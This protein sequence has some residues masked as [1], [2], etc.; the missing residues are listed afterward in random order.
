MKKVTREEAL[1]Y[2]RW[3]EDAGTTQESL[4]ERLGRERSTITNMLRLLKLPRAIQQDLIDERLSMGHAR[5][6]AGLRDPSEQKRL[7]D[8]ILSK[9]DGSLKV[10]AR[11]ETGAHNE[12]RCPP[13]TEGEPCWSY[14]AV[15]EFV[16]GDDP[17]YSTI[18]LN[19]SGTKIEA[20]ELMAFEE[21]T[22]LVFSNGGYRL[23]DEDG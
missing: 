20:G 18:L 7:R 14:A 9:V 1:A 16:P 23:I 15:Y 10:V 4:A 6:L 5:V 11:I 2:Q 21:T 22:R 12:Q 13:L 8:L 19:T 3:L 17:A